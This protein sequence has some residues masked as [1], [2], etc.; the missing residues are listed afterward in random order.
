MGVYKTSGNNKPAGFFARQTTYRRGK[1]NNKNPSNTSFIKIKNFQ[2]TVDKSIPDAYNH[3]K[4]IG[5]IIKRRR[6]Y[7]EPLLWKVAKR[8]LQKWTN[9]ELS[10]LSH[11]EITLE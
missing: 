10:M 5:K 9:V 7:D 11:P 2:K 3:T 1:R 8:K 4:P 6:Q